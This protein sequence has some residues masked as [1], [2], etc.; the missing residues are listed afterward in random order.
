[1]TFP[2]A[3][4][5]GFCTVSELL[6][7][8][9]RLAL[10]HFQ[11]GHVWDEVSASRLLES[12]MLDTPCGSIILWVPDGEL[13]DHGEPVAEW[14]SDAPAFL[15]VD[16]QQR[17]TALADAWNPDRRWA[18]NRAAFPGLRAG[19]DRRRIESPEG[20]VPWPE[21]PGESAGPTTRAN[22]PGRVERLVPLSEIIELGLRAWADAPTDGP[23]AQYW[24]QCVAG[25]QAMAS[26]LL[27]V[28]VKRGTPLPEIV[29]LY[30]RIN[31]SG[32]AVRKEER[33]F[34]AMVSYEPGT[35]AWL[36]G[37]FAAAHPE[38]GD[39]GEPDRNAVLKRARERA[40]G[41]SLFVSAYVQTVGHHRGAGTDLDLLARDDANLEWAVSADHSQAMLVESQ[42]IVATTARVLRERLGCDDF[43][44]LPS[45][46]A[47]RPVFTLL[48]KYPQVGEQ[49]VAAAL[50]LTQV[51]EI[52]GHMR[53]KDIDDAIRQS[54]D[55]GEAWDALPC[56]EALIGD[57]GHLNA[58][59]GEVRSMTD[60][61]VS[62]LY[63]YQRGRGA[64][65]YLATPGDDG[66]AGYRPLDRTACAQKEHIV[67]FSLLY[68]AF[69]VD[70][71]GHS[72]RHEINGIGNLTML[73][74]TANY[75]HMNEPVDLDQAPPG[76]LEAHHLDEVE[77][78]RGYRAAIREINSPDSGDGERIRAS[79]LE[80]LRLRT[81][82]LATGMHD[83]LAEV[84]CVPPE[85]PTMRP[86]PLLITPCA[87][88]LIRAQPWPA[89]FQTELLRLATIRDGS[90][91]RMVRT[92]GQR[93]RKHTIRLSGDGTELKVGRIVYQGQAI[94]DA[95]QAW[96]LPEVCA[97]SDEVAFV[98]DP[99]SEQA[100]RALQLVTARHA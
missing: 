27:Q 97:D 7:A 20:F 59:L 76:L 88:D 4:G 47:L 50:L 38:R 91:W 93:T 75:A 79:Y 96:H 34:A 81:G 28:V 65:D 94:I 86:T 17:L 62:L 98:I 67:P 56:L 18:L 37:C 22:Y 68:S 100:I 1:M 41:F 74:A 46:H 92:P 58:I 95:L 73:S 89:E 80:F 12:L 31:S 70:P 85:D 25:I 6:A 43:R 44:F 16:G 53:T 57:A 71:K 61:W 52:R 19:Q 45:A 24:A 64:R 15:V 39:H 5:N 23:V 48:L 77:V 60:P 90:D 29:A 82:A 11:R 8:L 33:A 14:G 63:W 40:F 54:N 32:V 21:P 84:T 35:S 55:L 13:S 10:P 83:W 49:P 72:A 9:P 99:N 3:G 42:R 66:I 51:H 78:L 87:A 26:R 30:N 2:P 36:R 69:G